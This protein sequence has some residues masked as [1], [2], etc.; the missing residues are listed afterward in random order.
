MRFKTLRFAPFKVDSR[1]QY[2]S[3]FGISS[4]DSGFLKI[5][6]FPMPFSGVGIPKLKNAV[7]QIP[8]YLFSEDEGGLQTKEI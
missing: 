7:F 5:F 4:I 6:G 2:S 3:A 1:F 8:D